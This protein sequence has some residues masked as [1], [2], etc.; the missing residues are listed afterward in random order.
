MLLLSLDLKKELYLQTL[1][2]LIQQELES[3]WLRLSRLTEEKW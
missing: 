3:T 1:V 2:T